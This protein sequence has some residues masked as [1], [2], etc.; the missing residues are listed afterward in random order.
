MDV[1]LR[2]AFGS[3]PCDMR[4]P[5]VRRDGLAE[6][7]ALDARIAV[8]QQQALNIQ[9]P[10]RAADVVDGVEQAGAPEENLLVVA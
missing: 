8:W 3:N 4:V 1:V 10:L 2:E 6:A 9:T 7:Y 5:L